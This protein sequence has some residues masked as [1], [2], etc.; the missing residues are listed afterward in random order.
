MMLLPSGN[1]RSTA[2]PL[3]DA[4]VLGQTKTSRQLSSADNAIYHGDEKEPIQE[5]YAEKV[6]S[7]RSEVQI[8]LREVGPAHG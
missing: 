4:V 1:A 8:S 2:V 5:Q 7:F 3:S 6:V